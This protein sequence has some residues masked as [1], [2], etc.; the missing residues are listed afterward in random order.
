[1]TAQIQPQI[2][3]GQWLSSNKDLA[4]IDLELS[5]AFHLNL[6]RAAIL[7]RPEQLIDNDTLP[8]LNKWA[9]ALRNHTPLAYLLGEQEFWS[10]PINVD[11]RVLVPRPDTE[12]LVEQGLHLIDEFSPVE[13]E[14]NVSIRALDLG[15]GSGA[16]A[17]ALAHER[18]DLQ[19][20][21]TDRS[22]DCLAVAGANTKRLNLDVEFVQSNWF[23]SLHGRWHI[24]VANP[25]YIDPIDPHL[26]HLHSEPSIALIAQEQG[27]ADLNTIVQ[28]A[29][30]FLVSGG[31]LLLEHGYDQ[32]ERVRAIM[33]RYGYQAVQSVRDLG[34]IERVTL[35][36]M[37]HE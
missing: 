7:A 18:P 13:A 12:L 23:A 16:I 25:P 11:A 5:L 6:S 29:P 22:A 35:G 19:V 28:G 9:D 36:R 10:L 34:G 33:K 37:D 32:A 3:I 24:I 1:M 20:C 14:A 21:A 4:R 2:S 30:P 17:L 26:Q 27:M 15:T 31:W 8:A